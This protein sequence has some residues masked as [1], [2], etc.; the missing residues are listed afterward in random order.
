ML[1]AEKV[2]EIFEDCLFKN[3]EIIDGKPIIEP[4]KVEGIINNFGFYPD[5]LKNHTVKIVELLNELPDNFKEWTGSGWTFLNACNDKEGSQWG[6]HCN[7]EQLVVL[8]IGIGKVKYCIPKEMW[9][10]LPG[11]M[12]YF[13]ILK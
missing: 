4:I 2:S 5:R 9:G 1:T 7:I 13:G 10:I 8:G 6:E 11:G 3:E 12:P